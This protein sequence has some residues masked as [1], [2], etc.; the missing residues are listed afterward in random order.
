MTCQEFA[1]RRGYLGPRQ[2]VCGRARRIR[3]FPSLVWQSWTSTLAVEP[4][5][6]SCRAASGHKRKGPSRGRVGTAPFRPARGGHANV[7]TEGRTPSGGRVISLDGASKNRL[8]RRRY[9]LIRSCKHAASQ[10]N[11]SSGGRIF[12]DLPRRLLLG[13]MNKW[14]AATSLHLS[15]KLLAL[16]SRPIRGRFRPAT[17]NWRP[18]SFRRKLRARPFPAPTQFPVLS[19]VVLLSDTFWG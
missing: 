2:R 10:I 4:P 7:S 11:C 12:N 6:V 14:S 17:P 8:S 5:V 18:S 19:C 3:F 1:I 15:S 16:C 9:R 13:P